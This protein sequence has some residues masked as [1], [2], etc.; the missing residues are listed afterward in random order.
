M[1]DVDEVKMLLAGKS[2]SWIIHQREK[3]FSAANMGLYEPGRGTKRVNNPYFSNGSQIAEKQV[4]GS[5]RP[6]RILFNG[7]EGQTFR[8]GNKQFVLKGV[9]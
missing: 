4:L 5:D 2:A 1:F 9:K 3:R 6:C 7:H 8:V